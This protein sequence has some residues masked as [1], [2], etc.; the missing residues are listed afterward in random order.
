M[1]LAAMIW[2]SAF[3]AQRLSAA[4]IGPFY[5][6]GLR[7]LL[8][9]LVVLVFC[10]FVPEQRK[11]LRAIPSDRG[12]LRAAGTLGVVTAIAIS[13]QQIG[14]QYTKVANAGFIT[15]LYV[16]LVP[17]MGLFTRHKTA[18]RTWIG[19]LLAVIGMYFLSVDEHFTIMAG[20][21]LQLVCAVV[22][23][24]QVVLIGRYARQ[25]DPLAL[26][27]A[28]FVATGLICMVV[29]VFTEPLSVASIDAAWP[30]ILYGGALSVGVAYTLQVVAQK[31][32]SAAHAAVIFS[33]EGL[34]A[35]IAGWLALGETLSPRAI[36]GCALMLAG[37]L[38]CQLLPARERDARTSPATANGVAADA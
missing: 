6:T 7:F 14:L 25:H 5:Y 36:G 22:I 12:L 16:I 9:A 31:R 21:G 15:S 30:T 23:S 24:A 10:L 35:A 33:M 27:I 18:A 8:G 29:A 13:A 38:A 28:Q 34:F 20:D 26:S 19:A 37:L 4:A 32:A 1:L 2:G 3:V 17:M 11:A